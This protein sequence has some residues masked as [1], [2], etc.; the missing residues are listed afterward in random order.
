MEN[1]EKRL[2]NLYYRLSILLENAVGKVFSNEAFIGINVNAR[3]NASLKMMQSKDYDSSSCS[4]FIDSG[5][6]ILLPAVSVVSKTLFSLENSMLGIYRSPYL[7]EFL[8]EDISIEDAVVDENL[9][10]LKRI[11]ARVRTKYKDKV[12]APLLR[13]ADK[14]LMIINSKEIRFNMLPVL[15]RM[16]IYRDLIKLDSRYAGISFEEDMLSRVDVH[17]DI[18]KRSDVTDLAC[19]IAECLIAA[20]YHASN[21]SRYVSLQSEG[22]LKVLSRVMEKGKFYSTKS[23]ADMLYLDTDTVIHLFILPATA[24]DRL[25][26]RRGKND[27]EQYSII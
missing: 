3:A 8:L 27:D 17:N 1:N 14:Y 13:L 5:Y 15:A 23:I 24:T 7:K 4:I 2:E 26:I 25:A 19:F 21:I 11:D 16:I 9:K 18:V 6:G 22:A 12:Y 10:I 20:L